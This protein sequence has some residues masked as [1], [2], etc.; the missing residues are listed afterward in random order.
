MVRKRWIDTGRGSLIHRLGYRIVSQ[1]TRFALSWLDTLSNELFEKLVGVVS[2]RKYGHFIL[3]PIYA[4]DLAPQNPLVLSLLCFCVQKH[5]SAVPQCVLYVAIKPDSVSPER[6]SHSGFQ[7]SS[8]LNTPARLIPT[9]P[10]TSIQMLW[11]R[12]PSEVKTSSSADVQEP[13]EGRSVSHCLLCAVPWAR[14]D[15]ARLLLLL[16]F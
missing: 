4:L 7:L 6:A 15:A 11:W 8:P 3:F 5:I 9:K 10:Y 12:W 2:L 14:A 1:S 13:W 16:S